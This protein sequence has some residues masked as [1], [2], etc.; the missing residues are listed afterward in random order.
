M[1]RGTIHTF[2]PHRYGRT[3]GTDPVT[4]RFGWISPRRRMESGGVRPA[5]ITR[6]SGFRARIK[7]RISP[8]KYS[9]PSMFGVQFMEPTNTRSATD[10]ESDGGVKKS[11]STP[12]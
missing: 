12:V 4:N 11:I 9:T 7:G 1:R 10:G 3:S 5:I 8:Q 2:D 6:Q